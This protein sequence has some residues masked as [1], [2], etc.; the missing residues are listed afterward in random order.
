MK[1]SKY[2]AFICAI[3]GSFAHQAM[4]SDDDSVLLN[5]KKD[6]KEKTS[7]DLMK[8]LA[9]GNYFIQFLCRSIIPGSEN[10]VVFNSSAMKIMSG[11][12]VV[13]KPD[14]C[15]SFEVYSMKTEKCEKQIVIN[16]NNSSSGK[17][18]FKFY[19]YFLLIFIF[20]C[21]L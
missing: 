16:D 13:V 14:T 2:L 4:D 9:S 19:Y 15:E 17:I 12:N 18:D 20:L 7:I 10:M 21:V 1:F 3:G 8:Q 5:R 11:E 6:N